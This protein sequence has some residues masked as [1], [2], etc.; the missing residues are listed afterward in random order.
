MICVDC[1]G[2]FTC[3]H[4]KERC[5]KCYQID[6][7]KKRK[8]KSGKIP[9]ECGCGEMIYAVTTEGKPQK[10]KPGH[11]LPKDAVGEKHPRWKGGV[12]QDKKDGYMYRKV[13]HHPFKN[14]NGQ[15]GE[16]RLVIEEY[17]TKL[18]GIKTFV[19][20]SLDIDHINGITDDNR[21]E[22]LRIISKRDHGSMHS[23]QRWS[24]RK[25]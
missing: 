1:G 7:R 22:N 10:Y 18:N 24:K 2:E 9:C 17:L 21:I 8:E 25:N 15:V 16:H 6:Y 13:Y 5:E 4:S 23:I 3:G 11:N 12:Y 14:R 19:H 20:P